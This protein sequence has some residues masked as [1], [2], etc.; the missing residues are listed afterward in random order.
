MRLIYSHNLL[1]EEIN[2]FYLFEVDVSL[3]VLDVDSFHGVLVE[4]SVRI[5]LP[6]TDYHQDPP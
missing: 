5:T 2:K 1:T 3:V 6:V 4:E